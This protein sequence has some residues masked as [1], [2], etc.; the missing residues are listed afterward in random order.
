MQTIQAD[1]FK[2]RFEEFIDAAH[3]GETFIVTLG[4]QHEKVAALIPY[5]QLEAG[6]PRTLGTLAGVAKVTF[7]DDFEITDKKLLEH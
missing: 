7:A 2:A 5:A 4:H 1:V 3:H 6:R